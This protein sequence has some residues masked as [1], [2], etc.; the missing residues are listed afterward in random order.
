LSKKI[1]LPPLKPNDSIE[2]SSQN[3][4][5]PKEAKQLSDLSW[6]D[7][8]KVL[9]VLFAKMNGTSLS[10]S[11]QKA[12]K[13]RDHMEEI[14][15]N[16]SGRRKSGFCKASQ[17]PTILLNEEDQDFDSHILIDNN[18]SEREMESHTEDVTTTMDSRSEGINAS[19]Y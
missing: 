14:R 15:E 17:M 10:K 9:R 6:A 11:G 1:S 13:I 5:E 7:K 4:D 8:E 2:S 12:E 16:A 19:A 3:D 18:Y